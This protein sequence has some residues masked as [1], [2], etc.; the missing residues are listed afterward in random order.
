MAFGIEAVMPVE[1]RVPTERVIHYDATNNVQGLSLDTDLLEKKRE[2][3][4]LR[5]LNNKQRIS[6]YYNTRVQA[7]PLILGD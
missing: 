5:N 2:A 1:L 4:H 6:R 3:E 7:R